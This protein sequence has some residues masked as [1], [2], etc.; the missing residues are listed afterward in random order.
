[1]HRPAFTALMQKIGT[2]RRKEP[3]GTLSAVPTHS[4]IEGKHLASER[5]PAMI[6]FAASLFSVTN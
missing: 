3:P 2:T 5:G 4:E 1:M 6:C